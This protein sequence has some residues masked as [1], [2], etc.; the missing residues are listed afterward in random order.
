MYKRQVQN[1]DGWAKA[2]VMIRESLNPGSEH[3]SVFITPSNGVAFQYRATTGGSSA[4]INTTGPVAPYWVKIVRSSNTFT[5]SYSVNGSTWTQLGS[6]TISMASS[7]YIGL[8]TTS[9]NDGVLS[10]A[11][12]TNITAV[13]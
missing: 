9:H 6:T 2:G 12:F 4:N 7:V 3:A 11:T 13:P 10:K 1:T 5:A 8:A